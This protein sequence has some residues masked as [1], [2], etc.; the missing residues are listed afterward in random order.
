MNSIINI[1]P[2][3]LANKIAAGEVV[4]RPES[5]IKELLENAI[6]A[7]ATAISITIKNA[8]KLLI[9]V[10]DN[11]KGMSEED[12]VKSFYRHAT[13]KIASYDDLE[14]IHTL[15]FRGE[16]L[17][18]VAAVAQVELKT[19]RDEDEVGTFIRTEGSEIKEQTKSAHQRGTTVSVKN[20][21]FNTPARRQFLKSNNTEFKHVYETIQ[22]LALSHPEIALEFVSDD[23]TILA[24]PGQ[25]LDERLKSLFG[26]RH[27]S[28]LI[29]V[30]E[31]TDLLSINGFVGKPDFARK[32][33]VDQFIFLNKRF[34][35][36]R[37]INHA[38]FSGYEHLVEKGNFPFF[39]LFIEL[40][41]HKVDVNVH[42]SKME[43]KFADEQSIYRIVMS[44]VRKALGQNDLMPTV[45][46]QS[47]NQT[48]FSSLHH[49]AQPRWIG[50]ER[51]LSSS[52]P[53]TP[54]GIEAKK[55]F[56]NEDF[57]FDLSSK[58]DQIFSTTPA[59]ETA[60]QQI[61]AQQVQHGTRE[62]EAQEGKAIWQLH[63]KYILSQIRSGLMIIDQHVAHERILYERALQR[64]NNAVP[65]SQQLLFPQTVQLT[66]GD[67]TLVKEVLP[68]LQSIGFETKIFGKNTIVLEGVPPEVK[69][70][71]E[72]TILQDILDEFKNNQLRV[73]L[74]ARDNVAKSFSCKAAIKAGE[75]LNEIEMRSL[76]DQ[77]FA[78]SM[79]YVC[80]HGRPVLI[81]ISLPELDR[82]FLR[83]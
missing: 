52:V 76:I 70:G 81:K 4:Q 20:L 23:D 45:E 28:T 56:E 10:T 39:L 77:L 83:T 35:I 69:A 79:P 27:F 53:N 38:V 13:S 31:T 74:D 8:G 62:S 75:K 51:G 2:E 67:F 65:S 61:E 73:K 40:D 26:D 6:D 71:T 3:H 57:P 80:P 37:S 49:V 25:G 32:S 59:T 33:K 36:S 63:N 64:F 78:T 7:E 9:R 34:I 50:D 14:N 55:Q 54:F 1:L 30:K 41:P 22:R 82:R 19:K 42:P 5:V 24:L 58:L 68:F 72:A 43:V 12:A 47:S 21:F 17:A 48:Q 11:G 66:S 15:G 18:S 16:A 60:Q 44:V 46:F 29:S